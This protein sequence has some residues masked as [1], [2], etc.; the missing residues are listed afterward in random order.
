MEGLAGDGISRGLWVNVAGTIGKLEATNA[1]PT[2]LTCHFLPRE[3]VY[4]L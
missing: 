3:P 2:D 1:H 4:P